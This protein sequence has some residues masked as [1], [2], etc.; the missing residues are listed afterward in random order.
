[1]NLLAAGYVHPDIW[2]MKQRAEEEGRAKKSR[3]KFI[4]HLLLSWVPP[5]VTLSFVISFELG[6]RKREQKRKQESLNA[7]MNSNVD[8]QDSGGREPFVSLSQENIPSLV[9]EPSTD[10]QEDSSSRLIYVSDT[11]LGYGGHG[12]VVFKGSLGKFL[13]QSL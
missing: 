9:V 2:F 7:A 4:I 6:R 10:V 1:M 5:A 13:T 11:V 8:T 3:Y 12:T